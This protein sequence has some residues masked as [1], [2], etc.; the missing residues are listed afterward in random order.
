M[1]TAEGK[2]VFADRIHLPGQWFLNRDQ[3]RLFVVAALGIPLLRE[4]AATP[5]SLR[6]ARLVFFEV[7]FVED[8]GGRADR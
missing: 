7:E 5:V 6:G 2:N 8:G 4:D 3:R 1:P